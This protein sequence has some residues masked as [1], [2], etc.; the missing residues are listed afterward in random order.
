MA[1]SIKVNE[2]NS[3]RY[4]GTLVDETTAVFA[5]VTTLTLTLYNKVSKAIINGRDVQNV[6]NTNQVTLFNTLQT[7]SVTG[8]TY[9]L[10]W[11][12]LPLDNPIINS[13]LK[14]EIHVALFIAKWS[15]V[16]KQMNHEVT[17]KVQNLSK[18][19]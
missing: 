1:F 9:N 7:D 15:G 17:I 6:L 18:L 3:G 16:A 8:E 4:R 5:A 14:E 10:E 11:N 12:M 2:L 19:P 13:G